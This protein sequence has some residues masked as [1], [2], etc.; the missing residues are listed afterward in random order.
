MQTLNMFTFYCLFAFI[1]ILYI[2]VANVIKRNNESMV[3]IHI[4][5]SYRLMRHS[6]GCASYLDPLHM[7]LLL[8]MR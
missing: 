8:T 4:Q 2:C 7:G 3:V 5:V 1:D 6:K